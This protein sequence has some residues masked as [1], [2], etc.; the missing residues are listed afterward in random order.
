[1]QKRKLSAVIL[2]G[3]EG[4]R[5][6]PIT[7]NIPKPLVPIAGIPCIHLIIELL[8]T[9][10]IEDI[11]ITLGC[12][13]EMIS[14]AVKEFCESA[15]KRIPTLI[16]EKSPR[17]TAGSLLD[18]RDR[19]KGDFVVIGGDCVCDLD[20]GQAIDRH[21]SSAALVTVVLSSANDPREYGVAV[22]DGDRISRFI[23]KPGWN[24]VYSNTVN[25]GIYI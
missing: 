16:T 23:E 20:L 15:G 19:I 6:R 8:Y 11:Y 3:G 18:L 9:Y 25:T 22:T 21:Y 7:E 13:A 14:F 17:G 10:G 12:K 2:A 1:M 4:V 24:R 5:L